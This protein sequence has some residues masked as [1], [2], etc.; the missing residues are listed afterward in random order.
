MNLADRLKQAIPNSQFVSGRK[1]LAIRCPYC[2]HTSSAGKKHMYIGL[3][4]DRPLL[5]NCFK[6]ESSGK[7]N[8]IFLSDIGIADQSLIND[9]ELHNRNNSKSIYM[10]Q[11]NLDVNYLTNQIQFRGD[12]FEDKL[13]YINSR[14]GLNLDTSVLMNMRIVF[15]LTPYIWAL[16]KN[17]RATDNDIIRLQRDYFGMLSCNGSAITLRCIRD[18]DRK[19]RYIIVKLYD[20][21]FT[22]MYSVPMEIDLRMGRVPVHIVE[23]QFDILSIYFNLCKASTGV[24][25]AAAGNK[26]RSAIDYVM[27]KGVFRMDLHLYFDNDDAGR[28]A[29]RQMRKYVSDYRGFFYSS[30][31]YVHRNM[32]GEKD[33]GVPVALIRDSIERIK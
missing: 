16:K 26:Y 8:R 17:L 23:G 9:I 5:Y 22:K 4:E 32:S 2:G 1:E 11:E 31:V 13:N 18:C 21:G 27:D 29:E 33:Y 30:S 24:Y 15:D 7:V 20:E 3:S 14:L 10:P 28:I 19:Y 25:I 6:C 12:Y